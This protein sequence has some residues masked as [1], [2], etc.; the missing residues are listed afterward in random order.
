MSLFKLCD[1][2]TSCGYLSDRPNNLHPQMQFRL[3]GQSFVS[4]HSKIG[5]T[6]MAIESFEQPILL[7]FSFLLE[8]FF[9]DLAELL[10]GFA[11]PTILK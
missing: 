2:H 9:T 11:L 8:I 1:T 7:Q 4:G 6:F 3:Y 10:A 5:V